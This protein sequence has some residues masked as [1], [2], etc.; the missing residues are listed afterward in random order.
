MNNN[1]SIRFKLIETKIKSVIMFKFHIKYYI[2][3]K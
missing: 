2:N 1:K 3:Q